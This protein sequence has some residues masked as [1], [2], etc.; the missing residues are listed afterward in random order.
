MNSEE[1]YNYYHIRQSIHESHTLINMDEFLKQEEKLITFKGYLP[2]H[3]RR[4][5]K[6][7]YYV[8]LE[9]E[10]LL[11]DVLKEMGEKRDND[12]DEQLQELLDWIKSN[13]QFQKILN[14]DEFE[15]LNKELTTLEKKI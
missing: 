1:E 15:K 8:N 3:I 13:P 2:Y 12:Y 4:Y 14:F 6:I 9:Q 5:M 7:N 10:N 11:E